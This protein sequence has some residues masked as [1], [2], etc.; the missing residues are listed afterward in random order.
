MLF[1]FSWCDPY[2]LF[3]ELAE[4]LLVAVADFFRQLRNIALPVAQ[5]FFGDIDAESK[6]I[7]DKP[8]P[9]LPLEQSAEIG[10]ADMQASRPIIKGTAFGL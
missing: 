5:H 9:L 2:G 1:I 10:G 6:Q 7:I 8:D 4:I 3:K